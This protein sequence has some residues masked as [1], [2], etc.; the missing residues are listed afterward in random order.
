VPEVAVRVAAGSETRGAGTDAPMSEREGLTS[1]EGVDQG[2]A[3]QTAEGTGQDVGPEPGVE[4]RV[5]G[6]SP[7]P[8]S[9]DVPQSTQPG[10]ASEDGVLGEPPRGAPVDDAQ[11]AAPVDMESGESRQARDQAGTGQQYQVG[12]G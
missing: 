4:Q 12:E 3:A 10:S 9:A 6:A 5:S 11:A 1:S 8:L 2:S 7:G